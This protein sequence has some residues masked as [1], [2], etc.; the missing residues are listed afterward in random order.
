MVDFDPTV[1]YGAL[2]TIATALIG[3]GLTLVV[4]ALSVGRFTGR[5]TENL[6]DITRRITTMEANEAK[7]TDVLVDIGKSKIE[8]ELLSRRIDDLQQH[9]SHRLAEILAVLRSQIMDDFKIHLDAMRASQAAKRG[10]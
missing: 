10:D 7:M 9:G 4:N 2:F 8:I 1:S 3:F 6:E 5:V